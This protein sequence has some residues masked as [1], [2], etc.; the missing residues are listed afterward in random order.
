MIET[1]AGVD[2]DPNLRRRRQP[3]EQFPRP[4]SQRDLI[5]REIEIHLDCSSTGPLRSGSAASPA[6]LRRSDPNLP[7]GWERV[8]G[9]R[10]AAI[11]SNTEERPR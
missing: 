1:T 11:V 2:D 8:R 6:L 10:Y 4:A 7:D 5:I 3:V 9:A